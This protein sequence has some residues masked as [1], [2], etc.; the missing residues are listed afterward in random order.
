MDHCH[1][2]NEL[3]AGTARINDNLSFRFLN[4]EVEHPLPSV[5]VDQHLHGVTHA[6]L[7]HRRHQ[8]L[9]TGDPLA[10]DREDDVAFLN[11]LL[12]GVGAGIELGDV[13][14]VGQA[15]LCVRQTHPRHRG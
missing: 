7:V 5:P 2:R 6:A 3:S 11:A 15:G 1:V 14:A 4:G 8:I 12:G 13:K 10:V 9:L